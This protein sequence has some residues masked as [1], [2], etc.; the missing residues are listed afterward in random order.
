MTNMAA[1]YL[2]EKITTI[3]RSRELRHSVSDRMYSTANIIDF[4]Y[5]N[6]PPLGF[7][8]K[9]GFYIAKLLIIKDPLRM[10]PKDYVIDQ[11]TRAGFSRTQISTIRGL[12]IEAAY[13][14]CD[15]MIAKYPTIMTQTYQSF[16]KVSGFSKHNYYGPN[17]STF[18]VMDLYLN[19]GKE[20]RIEFDRLTL[21]LFKMKLNNTCIFYWPH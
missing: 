8:N 7:K 10:L 12:A 14:A 20:V 19:V 4:I 13:A 15:R 1:Q 6:N 21:Q 17:S 2:T 3:K 18:S 5:G 9:I 16:S 11:L